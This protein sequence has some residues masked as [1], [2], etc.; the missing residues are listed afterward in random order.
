[1]R[2]VVADA[3]A[4]VEYLLRTPRE[5]AIGEIVG[6]PDV[7]IHVPALCDIEVAAVVRR[8]LNSEHVTSDDALARAARKHTSLN[9]RS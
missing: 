4:L 1:M 9:V 7:A 6:K 3:S 8:A 2:H 5:A